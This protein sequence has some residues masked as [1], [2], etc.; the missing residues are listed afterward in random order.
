MATN[1]KYNGLT[2]EELSSP[3]QILSDSKDAVLITG[4]A[5][6]EGVWKNVIYSAKELKKVAGHL[7]G[8]PLIVE[9]GQ[10]KEFGNTEVG[11]VIESYFEPTLKGI[12]FKAK[13]TN[14]LAKKLV[15]KNILPAVSCSTWMDKK[16]VNE[17]IKIGSDY[18][19]AELSLC[20]VPACDR[21][22]IFHK[23]QLSQFTAGKGLN[24][25]NETILD[26]SEDTLGET[27]EELESLTDNELSFDDLEAPKLYTILELPDEESLSSLRDNRNVVSY[28]WGDPKDYK[29][30]KGK[31]TTGKVLLAVVELES[32]DELTELKETY[33]IKDAYYGVAPQKLS[34]GNETYDAKIE[35][36]VPGPEQT[37]NITC[38]ICDTEYADN[39]EFMSHW[40]GE[41]IE[42]YGKF[43]E[44]MAILDAL[45]RVE[46]LAK[47]DTK[48]V[49]SKKG[50]FLAMVDTGKEG[51]IKYKIIGSFASKKDAQDALDKLSVQPKEVAPKKAVAELKAT[52]PSCKKVI[53]D[54]EIHDHWNKLHAEQFGKLHKGELSKNDKT[55]PYYYFTLNGKYYPYLFKDGMYYTKYSK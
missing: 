19:F 11:S 47:G 37:G 52:C 23:E 55:E 29:R 6:T 28:F 35:V 20:R 30:Y 4:V 50:K 5:L 12:V 49:K 31:N 9:H 40:D 16:P 26:I 7:V 53:P 3:Y 44:T 43:K 18:N 54:K 10:T 42:Q 51:F 22:F 8:K 27:I 48:I 46:D 36:E 24:E 33:Q 41:H 38:P 21:C 13:V 32:K 34:N 1:D 17:Q 15:K 25:Q 2:M 39:T 45:S 14:S